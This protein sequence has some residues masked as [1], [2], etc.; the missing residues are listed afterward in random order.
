MDGGGPSRA[1]ALRLRAMALAAGF[2][3]DER[4]VT[5][6]IFSIMFTVILLG[7]AL[8]IDHGRHV[9]AK[10]RDQ[11][12]LDAAILAAS[13]Q[14]GLP[15][16]DTAGPEKARAFYRANVGADSASTIHSVTFDAA[17]GEVEATAGE[18]LA[19]TLMRA[20]GY[21]TMT[22]GVRSKVARGSNS[23][24]IA[25]VLDNSGSMGASSGTEAGTYLGDLKIAA[26]NLV[27]TVYAG[28]EGT[29]KVKM[30]VVPFAA[31]VNV[32]AEYRGSPW[33]DGDAD[34]S[35][36]MEN[37]A[38]A[39]RRFELFDELGVAWRGCVEARPAPLDVQ[40]TA[41]T[42]GDTL[43]VPMFAVDE[44]GDSGSHDL[45]YANSYINDDGGSCTPYARVCV[46]GFTKRGTCKSWAVTR[47]PNPD[48]QARTCKY[49]GVTPS[50][51][52][53]PNAG[54]TTKPILPLDATKANVLD[55]IDAM[56]ASGNTNVGEGLMWG[57]RTLSP[58]APF[59]EG[60]PYES[61]DS[62]KYVVLMTDGENRISVTSN[63]NKSVYNSYGYAAKGRLGTTYSDAGYT[64]KLNERM[65]LACSNAKAAGITIFTVAFNLAESPEVQA[66]LRDCAS[67]GEKALV[68]NDGAALDQ[69]FQS[70][71]RQITRLRIAG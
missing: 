55:A 61:G 29:E 27:N 41:P 5:A 7:A 18:T 9:S 12:A 53:G 36:H 65:R 44:P 13:D 22:V 24:E 48:A 71:G 40:D 17:T 42:S 64:A 16:Q 68:A 19:T 2:R 56:Q 21:E 51:A 37:F 25:L 47:L 43:F 59:T 35:I 69:A 6:I 49:A 26:R 1:A 32:G 23:V 20:L 70:I 38:E 10:M 46:G 33:I 15:D 58:G 50:G 45:G 62:S 8:A 54:C 66:L 11:A 67:G 30:A 57:W 28:A 60:R 31:S 4:G 14:L 34:S 39:R 3:G 63:H 52:T